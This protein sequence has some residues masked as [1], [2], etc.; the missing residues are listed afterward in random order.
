MFVLNQWYVAGFIWELQD[1][2]LARTLLNQPVVL[3]R[4]G[5]GEVAALED[6]CCHRS[7]PLSC[8]TLEEQ[9]LRCGYHGLLFAPGGQCLDIPGQA[10]V[11]G[12]ACVRAYQVAVRNQVIWIWMGQT[13]DEPAHGEPPEIAAHDDPRYRFKGG[14][15]HYQAP[16]QLIHDNLLDLSHVGYV[17]GKTIGGNARTHME[18]PTRVSSQDRQVR[19]VRHMLDSLPPATYSAAWPF[20]GRIDRWQ[21]IDFEVSHL[22]IFTGAVDAGSEPVDNPGRGGFH[23]RGFHGITPETDNTTH[24]F[25]TMACSS[26]PDMPDNLEDVYQ[27]TAATFE[28]DRIIIEAQYRNMRQFAGR[29]MI[30]IHVDVGANRARR[31]IDALTAPQQTA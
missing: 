11:P 23:M 4:T 24:Y 9:G 17:H 12:K 2:P 14:V 15:F 28:E 1:R 25:W 13:A 19:V 20:R 8:G 31:I 26:H 6:R 18:A 3:F 10:K 16:Y 30:D 22:N 5:Q 21:E 29:D 7:L 27:Q